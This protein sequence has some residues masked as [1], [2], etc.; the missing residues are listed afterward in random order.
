MLNLY[1]FHT[2]PDTLDQKG[3]PASLEEVYKHVSA[4]LEN[5]AYHFNDDPDSEDRVTITTTNSDADMYQIE[6]VF[7]H[8]RETHTRITF[9]LMLREYDIVIAGR[10]ASIHQPKPYTR[11][12]RAWEYGMFD[13][14]GVDDFID[15]LL[16][17]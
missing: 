13:T 5:Y 7:K 15:D 1:Q 16:H 10:N 12:M 8:G 6:L 3:L 11:N 9:I 14:D 2:A 4:H 17:H